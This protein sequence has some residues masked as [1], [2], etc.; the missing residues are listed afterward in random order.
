MNKF[1]TWLKSPSSDGTLFIIVLL[2][3][4]IVGQRAFLRFDLTGPRSYS[5]SP[6]SVQLV[7]TLREPL[8]VKVFFSS[9]LPAPYNSVEQYVRDLLVEY[10]GA[11]N[12]NFS[13]AFFDMDKKENQQL[14]SDYGIAQVQIQQ[15]SN[16]EVGIKE[17][18]MGLAIV[19][20]D[21]I[22]TL[23][24]L[25]TS[26]GLEYKLT[27]AMS[28]MIS[29][30]DALA[31]LGE[32]DK[33][34]LT[35]YATGLLSKFKISGFDTMAAQVKNAYEAINKK[36]MN[37]IEFD[38]VDPS[39]S[40]IPTLAQKYGIQTIT[41]K[42][43]GGKQ[44]QGALGLVLEYKDN[45]R[46]I[47]LSMQRSLFG[48]T[49]VGLD[50]LE[51]SIGDSLRSLMTRSTD[52]GYVTNH[53]EPSI[54]D[55]QNGAGNF[56]G[57]LSDF[58]TLKE[59][60]LSKDQIPASLTTLIVNGPKKAFT[61][62]ELYKIDQFIMRGG[63]VLFFVDPFET[64]QA[65]YY[66]PPQYKPLDTGLGKLLSAYGVSLGQ[67][68][69]MDEHC[70][71][72]I[73]QGYGKLS[74]P[75]AP[76]LAQ[77]QLAP[78]SVITKNLGD[79]IFLQNSAVDPA[80]ALANKNLKVT[81]LAKSSPQSWLVSKNIMLNPLMTAAPSDKSTEKSYDLAVLIEGKFKSAFGAPPQ[82]ASGQSSRAGGGAAFEEESG[83]A[84]PLA[85]ST[86]LAESV[87]PGKIFVTGSSELTGP[88][89]IDQNGSQP[90]ALFVRN[91]VDYM[92]GAAD[93][94]TMRTKGLSLSRLSGKNSG[95]AAAAT[96][97]NEFGLTILVVAAGLIVWRAR[98]RRRERIRRRYNPV[99]KPQEVAR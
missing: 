86:H 75:W 21:S 10:K 22:K 74:L 18:W 81:V 84:G 53:D 30:A 69:V 56:N 48:Y 85:S 19:Y 6:A 33:V 42:D 31:G 35:L 88:Q 67:N 4:N 47:P 37:R 90:V 11:A 43:E 45:F 57:L 52:V 3:A 41:W 91:I 92:S 98:V 95:A 77:R 36:N 78:S 99:E 70:Y 87:L 14:A 46:L 13:Y 32:H 9:N 2:L 7:K 23:D 29:S 72:T 39:P 50:A 54:Y 1:L 60:D 25:T 62:E 71:T 59:I 76:L 38:T 8:S 96:F 80:S 63:N 34:K 55:Q 68:Y 26:D 44:G 15:L 73:Q 65:S 20:Q 97:F 5:L 82:A 83:S 61:D 66:E 27:T 28:K 51:T 49:I 93:F 40:D 24:S 16:N 79:L 89:L 64:T 58:Y 17:V 94:C 12:R